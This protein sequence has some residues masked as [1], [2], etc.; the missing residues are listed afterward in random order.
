MKAVVARERLA[1]DV[2]ELEELNAEAKVL[3]QRVEDVLRVGH[4]RSGG[5]R[6]R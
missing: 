6:R 4:G 5:P 1:A 2:R 3:N